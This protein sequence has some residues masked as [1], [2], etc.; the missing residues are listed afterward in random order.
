MNRPRTAET[1]VVRPT[2]T[3]QAE[4][5]VAPVIA[6]VSVAANRVSDA[7]AAHAAA[8]VAAPSARIVRRSRA[9]SL[10]PSKPTTPRSFNG[11]VRQRS[12]IPAL[13][14]FAVSAFVGGSLFNPMQTDAA[15]A[16]P[17]LA[18]A[19]IATPQQFSAHGTYGDFD[20]AR[21]GFDVVKPAPKPTPT[22][23]AS[24]TPDADD[25]AATAT[26]DTESTDDAQPAA[27]TPLAATA[28]T[29][30]PGSA[31]AIAQQMVTARGWGNDQ[32]SCL[33]SLWNKESGWRVN[34]Y[35]PSGAYG[36]PQSLPGSKMASAGADWQTNPA[37]Q[38]TWGLNYITGVYGTPCGAWAHSVSYNWY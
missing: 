11:F 38:I 30:D 19:P 22:P 14:F 4:Q 36:I 27:S 35:N 31:Q 5:R 1:T 34:A 18:P 13:S 21:D 15:T 17:V 33:V 23:S 9:R 20:A 24:A 25:T 28:A 37:T 29:P 12:T 10:A 32:Y 8:V 7:D 6:P 26:A 2:P 3:P 16:A